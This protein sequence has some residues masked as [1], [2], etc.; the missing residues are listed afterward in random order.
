MQV[1]SRVIGTHELIIE[2]FYPF[3]QRYLQPSQRDVTV[4]LACVV[5]ACHRLVPP[6]VLHPVLKQLVDQFVHDK[7]R[8]EVMTVGL[9]SVREMCIRSPL[10]MNQELL[11][12]LVL[13]KKFKDKHVSNAAKS[14]V[15]LFRELMPKMLEK[16]DRGRGADLSLEIGE[17]GAVA[18]KDRCVPVLPF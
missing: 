2:N 16:R 10:V 17:Y 15:S 8:P 7:A 14:L 4:V 5:Q 18:L 1:I 13:Y 11:S 6:D 3:L 9:K 12:D